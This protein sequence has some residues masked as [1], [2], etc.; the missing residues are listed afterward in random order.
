MTP[1]PQ[2]EGARDELGVS[3]FLPHVTT[4]RTHPRVLDRCLTLVGALVLVGAGPAAAQSQP[5]VV[6]ELKFEGNKSLPS[7]ML[8]NSISTTVSSWFARSSVVRWIGLGEKRFFNETEFQRDVLRLEVIYRRSGFPDVRVDTVVKRTPTDVFATFRI[9]EGKP[10]LLTDLAISG[11]DSLSEK[12]R[13]SVREG[14]PLRTGQPF[15]LALLQASVDT[16]VW[17]L[18]SRG[19]P[20]ADAFREYA[21]DSAART[22]TA[23]IALEP[24]RRMRVGTI[25]VE[26]T[27][28]VDSN[29]VRALMVTREGRVYSESEL[30]SSQA[31]LYRSDL[32]RLAA[33]SLDTAAF[34]P[35]DTLVP[36]VVRVSESL[37]YRARASAGYATQDCFRTSAGIAR[38]NFLG[39]GRILDVSGRLSK[40][41]VGA[42]T[43]FGLENRFLCSALKDDSIGSSK[44]NYNLTA[45]VRRPA[46]LSPQASITVSAF[47]ERRSEFRIYLRED[48]GSSIALTRESS[49]WR[50]PIT[51]SYTFSYG[52]TQATPAVFC[53]FFNAC[54][55]ET[56]S[57]QE[58][59]RPLA[60]LGLRAARVR[61]NNPVEPGRG[62]VYSGEA[63]WSST[64]IGSSEFQQFTRFVAEGRWYTTLARDVVLATRVRSG[65]VIGGALSNFDVPSFIPVEQRFY[66]G[67]PN[68]VRGYSFNQ[69]GPVVY[70]AD[71]ADLAESGGVDSLSTNDVQAFATG[72]NT[73]A[74]GN[75]ELRVPSPFLRSALRIALFL[76]VGTV[77]QRGG[78]QATPVALR[79]T[80]GVGVRLQTPVGPFRLDVAYNPY[81]LQPGILYQNQP[82]GDLIEVTDPSTGQ[83]FQY[84]RPD[85]E[86]FKF[87]LTVGQPF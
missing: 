65:V 3:Y 28:R 10:I 16:L 15:N 60:M 69:L 23:G 52:R 39:S 81:R 82:N 32:F 75:V 29:V 11:L 80:P 66:G 79:A 71:S 17:R 43:D 41:G 31:N 56:R 68:D 42:P 30:F 67:G 22:A 13:R 35:L 72:G 18:R 61:V 77:W 40:I 50:D 48:I 14:L 9:M 86:G 44:L 62:S 5:R 70:V 37:R 33:V 64:V 47:S 83:P 76:D 53:S 24:G 36:L 26:G 38:R 54:T 4:G 6:R 46:F 85:R 8:A 49:I 7:T 51:L 2:V 58:Q 45:S 12:E 74:V 84:Q 27:E 55:A 1:R 78:S 19:Y 87:N 20:R 34:D 57:L 25:R 21:V 59:R 63:A 73:L